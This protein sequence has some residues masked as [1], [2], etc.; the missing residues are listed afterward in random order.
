MIYIISI[1]FVISKIW[2]NFADENKCYYYTNMDKKI[3]FASLATVFVLTWTSMLTTSCQ[4]SLEERCARESKEFNEKKCPAK[5]ADGVMLDSLVFERE[6]HTLHYYYTFSGIA[7][8]PKAMEQMNPRKILIDEV[9]NSTSIKTYKD[10]KY[11]FH[12][13]YHSA[14]RK[15]ILADVVVTEKDYK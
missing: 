14:S 15:T 13:T 8:D 7:D 2:S 6:S 11:K 5:V 10:A 1:L 9:R 3:V 12:Y 4:E